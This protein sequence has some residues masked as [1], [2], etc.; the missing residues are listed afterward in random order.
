MQNNLQANYLNSTNKSFALVS[1]DFIV[2]EPLQKN[3]WL[4]LDVN[5]LKCTLLSGN[6]KL[7]KAKILFNNG[8]FFVKFGNQSKESKAK[9][10]KAIG[11]VLKIELNSSFEKGLFALSKAPL[12][13]I[14]EAKKRYIV[15]L[16]FSNSFYIKVK[17]KI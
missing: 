1:K 11:A 17:D 10:T 12:Q 9:D 7:A 3:S 14:L 6:K 16:Y 13:A 15:E 4:K 5:E 2:Q 8:Y